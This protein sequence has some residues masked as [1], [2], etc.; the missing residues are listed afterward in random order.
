MGLIKV[1]K[2]NPEYEKLF[3][4]FEKI[5]LKGE[6]VG[7]R[8]I[9]MLKLMPHNTRDYWTY[10]GSLTTPPCCESVQWIVFREPVEIS[11]EQVR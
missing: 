5:H 6:H 2:F 3:G 4:Q 7:V 8:N 1:G 9:D 10:P 11:A